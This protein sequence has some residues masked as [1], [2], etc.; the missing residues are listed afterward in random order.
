V[1]PLWLNNPAT[2]PPNDPFLSAARGRLL[3]KTLRK[4][5]EWDASSAKSVA[6]MGF[7]ISG[8][9]NFS[10]I[11][12]MGH[13]RGGAGV[14][15]AYNMLMTPELLPEDEVQDFSTLKSS[16]ESVVEVAPLEV[17]EDVPTTV[18]GVPWLMVG[19]GCESDEVDYGVLNS[20]RYPTL[21][22]WPKRITT[23]QVDSPA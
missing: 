9:T 15:K 6:D 7:D 17:K 14:R 21:L 23:L 4:V 8:S 19:A 5:R 1:D 12:L 2:A 3:L 13:S 22:T 10:S 16:I 18:I 20:P 11:G